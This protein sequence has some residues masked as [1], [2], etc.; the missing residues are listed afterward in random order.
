MIFKIYIKIVNR[1]LRDKRTNLALKHLASSNNAS[2]TR[3]L[4]HSSIL[5][6]HESSN[7]EDAA[8]FFLY[9]MFSK[10]LTI[11]NYRFN[12]SQNQENLQGTRSLN[13]FLLPN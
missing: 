1:C 10:F 12:L 9:Y 4:I 2:P 6:K 13:Q 5:S 3:K 7:N 8:R 11:Y